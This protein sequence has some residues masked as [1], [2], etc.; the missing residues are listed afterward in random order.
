M[1]RRLSEI[2]ADLH[3]TR[4]AARAAPMLDK[5]RHASQFMDF[6]IEAIDALERRV[7]AGGDVAL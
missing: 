6:V 1:P 7:R 4:D 3:R 2:R 5:A